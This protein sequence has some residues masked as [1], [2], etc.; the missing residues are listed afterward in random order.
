MSL[1]LEDMRETFH[2][3]RFL[4]MTDNNRREEYGPVE[5][6]P[7][8]WAPGARRVQSA[9]GK[10]VVAT[11]TLYTTAVIAQEDLEKVLIWLPGADPA[12]YKR[13]RKP[14]QSFVHKD[15]ETGSFDHSEVVL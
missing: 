11:G 9:E 7:C 14:V 6:H 5:P 4:R 13:S 12:D 2:L 15:L 1:F 3:R 8:R 10:Q